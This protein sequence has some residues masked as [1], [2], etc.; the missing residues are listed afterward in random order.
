MTTIALI[1]D[2]LVPNAQGVEL[3]D[4]M[5]EHLDKGGNDPVLAWL[6]ANGHDRD[7]DIVTI[8]T[9]WF[10]NEERARR[11]L[12]YVF[13]YCFFNQTDKCKD[14]LKL[15]RGRFKLLN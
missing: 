2:P 15:V 10:G 12:Y 11:F 4:F 7:T 3:I 1:E 6:E 9:P 8:W 14:L 13:N 5:L